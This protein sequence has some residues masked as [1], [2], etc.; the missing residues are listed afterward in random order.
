MR[1]KIK[2]ERLFYTLRARAL[3]IPSF[4]SSS[5][6]SK[7]AFSLALFPSRSQV[8]VAREKRDVSFFLSLFL[9]VNFWLG[10]K[11]DLKNVFHVG[12]QPVRV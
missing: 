1:K 7:L 12:A 2:E 10:K 11:R 5:S 6:S 4:S 9:L 3:H 8:K